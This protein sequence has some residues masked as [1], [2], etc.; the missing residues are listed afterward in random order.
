MVDPNRKINKHLDISSSDDDEDLNDEHIQMVKEYEEEFKDRFTEQDET[1]MNFCKQK[2]KP[3]V[4]VYPFDVFHHRGGGGG[5]GRYNNQ[6]GGRN[7][8]HP[9]NRNDHHDNRRNFNHQ[10]NRYHNQRPSYNNDNHDAK[11]FRRDDNN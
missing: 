6:R 2:A 1:F 4:I 5:G 3:P 8:H 10:N 11:R 9:Y 7:F